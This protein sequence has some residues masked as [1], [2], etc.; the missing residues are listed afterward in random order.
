MTP[1]QMMAVESKVAN[2][3]KSP[4]LAFVL[5]FFFGWL[6]AH[7]FYLN[8]S[9]GLIQLS[10]FIISIVVVLIGAANSPSLWGIPI[11]SPPFFRISPLY[12]IGFIGIIIS[13]VW[14]FIDAF[15]ILRW[16]KEN[17][18][19]LREDIMRNLR[20]E[21]T[22]GK[23]ITTGNIPTT[24]MIGNLNDDAYKIFLTKKF[25]IEFNQALNK[26]IVVDKLLNSIDEALKYADKINKNE[27][28][29]NQTKNKNELYA[30]SDERILRKKY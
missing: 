10:F 23:N 20:W 12:Y 18:N 22:A 17:N 1:E 3:G 24:S 30:K 19:I 5:W 27:I 25:N 26:Y 6:G 28:N 8:K 15:F 7:R 29:I 21:L 14:E 11:Y 16:I 9:G 2:D 4:L 13:G